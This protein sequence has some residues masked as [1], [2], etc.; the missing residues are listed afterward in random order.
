MSLTDRDR[1]IALALVPLILIAV[2]WF[3][4]LAPKRKE[5]HKLSAQVT[6]AQQARDAAVSQANALE[7]ARTNFATQYA[8]MV[9]LGKAIPT[10][11]DMPSLLVQLNAA[12]RGTGIQFGD[13]KVGARVD[14]APVSSS[15]TT[16]GTSST[17]TTGATGA[18]GTTG[19]TG[20]TA[21]PVAAGGA[22]AQTT[23]GKAVESANNTA[24]AGSAQAAKESEPAVP[25]L[26]PGTP[27]PGLDTVPLTFTF[28]GKFD[29]LAAFFHQ[30]KRFVHVANNKI[31][32]QGRLI[33]I[34]SL[35]FTSSATNFP[36]IEADVSATVYL[37]PKDGGAT[38]GATSAG[39]AATTPDAAS[40]ASAAA[41][42]VTPP[43][44]AITR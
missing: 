17:G 42:A 35:K 38:G 9:R 13:M 2:Y 4:I 36:D 26:T 5:A 14:A 16:P 1:K 18:T 11:V 24:A 27:V 20:S 22:T 25:Q 6:S 30:L 10:E 34:D 15:T 8:Q 28:G 19:A 31:S 3:L 23:F 43:T 41:S 37:S 12:A 29:N 32:V 40:N 21:P 7:Q 33:T 44:S 39:P